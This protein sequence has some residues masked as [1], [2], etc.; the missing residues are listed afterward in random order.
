MFGLGLLEA[1]PAESLVANQVANARR[2]DA[3][4]GHVNVV[5]DSLRQGYAIGRFGLKANV[6]SLLQQ[7]AGAFASDMGVSNPVFPGEDGAA[8]IESTVLHEVEMYMQTLGV[9]RAARQDDPVVQ[10]GALLF[11]RAKC[12][13]CHRPTLYTGPSPLVALSGQTIHPFTDLLVHDMGTGLADG[14]SDF[15]ASGR[16]WRTAPLWGIGLTQTVGGSAVGFL[17]DG[18][19]R[20]LEEAIL[21]HGGEAAESKRAFKRMPKRERAAL[22]AFLNSL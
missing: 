15:A 21:W 18:R 4:R 6:A 22:I 16:E 13:A 7:V 9:P 8:E 1:V 14:R 5:W 20:S 11:A 12:S 17:H 2:S 10:D 3:I 19:A